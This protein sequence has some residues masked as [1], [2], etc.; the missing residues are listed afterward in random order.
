MNNK[1]STSILLATFVVASGTLLSI[2][3][4]IADS[5]MAI[6]QTLK[7]SVINRAITE[8]EVLAAQKAWGEALVAIS[9]TL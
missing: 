4:S 2:Q 5:S 8:S 7:R 3:P 1:N 9:V 6:S